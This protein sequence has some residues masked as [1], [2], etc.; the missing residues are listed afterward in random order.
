[1]RQPEIPLDMRTVC[2]NRDDVIKGPI[3]LRDGFGADLAYPTVSRDD[4]LVVDRADGQALLFRVVAHSPRAILR[5]VCLIARSLLVSSA[6]TMGFLPGARIPCAAGGRGAQIGR[7]LRAAGVFRASILFADALSVREAPRSLSG[8]TPLLAHPNDGWR[9]P[10]SKPCA[11]G[12]LSPASTFRLRIGRVRGAASLP[13]LLTVLLSVSGG[14]LAYTVRLLTLQAGLSFRNRCSVLAPVGR[15]VLP[16]AL[17]AQGP[18]LVVHR[19]DSLPPSGL[20]L[21]AVPV[22]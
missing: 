3:A 16:I 20:N 15:R 11:N 19:G 6:V 12:R 10:T 14:V 18:G 22:I 8:R 9:K 2:R 13:D 17:R 5:R 1:M 4:G 21:V 7:Y